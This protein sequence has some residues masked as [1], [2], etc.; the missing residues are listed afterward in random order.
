MDL[1]AILERHAAAAG[2]LT[3]QQR[4]A[5]A[6]LAACRTAALGGRLEQC[7][8]C[9]HQHYHYTLD[10]GEPASTTSHGEGSGEMKHHPI[11]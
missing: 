4:R 3:A 5:V 1:G 10:E 7:A 8:A 2:P 6:D 11:E 9:G